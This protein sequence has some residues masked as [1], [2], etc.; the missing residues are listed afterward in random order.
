[1]LGE[2]ISHYRIREELGRGGMGVVY[3]AED[4]RLGRLVALKFVPDT[5]AA[6]AQALERFRRE[7]QAASRLNHPN[8]CTVFDVG[9]H[10]GRPFIIMELLE[11]RT[12]FQHIGRSPLPVEQILELGIQLAD[13]ID[14]A[15]RTGIIHRDIKSTNIFV[16]SRGQAKVLDFGLVKLQKQSGAPS[17]L[18]ETESLPPESLT[19]PGTAIGTVAWMSPEQARGEDVDQRSDVYSL[20]VVLYEMATGTLPFRGK[21][22]AIIFDAILNQPPEAASDR[23]P[24]LPAELARILHRALEKDREVRYQTA[25]DLRADLTR[26]QRDITSGKLAVETKRLSETRR[27]AARPQRQTKAVMGAA[28]CLLIVVTAIGWA[29]WR[30]GAENDRRS[31]PREGM[32]PS[33]LIERPLTANPPENF[34]ETAAISPQGTYLAYNGIYEKLVLRAVHSGEILAV[35]LPEGMSVYHVSWFPEE[36]RLLLT[37]ADARGQRS[38]WVTYIAGGAPRKL[39]GDV[40]LESAVSPNGQQIAFTTSDSQEIWLMSTSGQNARRLLQGDAGDEF[41]SLDWYPGGHRILYAR[42]TPPPTGWAA[43][44]ES[45]DTIDAQPTSILADIGLTSSDSPSCCCLPNGTVVYSLQDTERETANLWAVSTDPVTGQPLGTPREIADDSGF[46]SSVCNAT[47]DGRQLA[48][49]RSRAQFDVYVAELQP[50]SNRLLSPRRLTLDD[51]DDKLDSWLDN[52]T[53]LF[54]S[55]RS[56]TFDIYQQAI[57][58]G[59]ARVVIATSEDDLGG[60]TN[61]DGSLLI[62]A[63]TPSLLELNQGGAAELFCTPIDGGTPRSLGTFRHASFRCAPS[64]DAPNVVSERQPMHLVF[65][66]LDLNSGRGP[67]LARVEIGQAGHRDWDLAADGN[68]IVVAGDECLQI[69]SLDNGRVETLPVSG[70]SKFQRVA[71][72]ANGQGVFATPLESDDYLLL[73]IGL[74][75][76]TRE[77]WRNKS[78]WVARL[79]PSPDGRHLAFMAMT[80]ESNVW[81]LENFLPVAPPMKSSR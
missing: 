37:L 39:R 79:R 10:A 36:T 40:G 43:A 33:I 30:A 71:W 28:A 80:F 42:L 52:Q 70:Y 21:T 59:P 45:C 14:A 51:R 77:V 15:H 1:M 38:I 49:R 3:Q 81:L 74:D 64:A 61:H 19:S 13:A 16:S 2:T 11:G 54:S 73:Y 47:L 22:T 20:G 68:R 24:E 8:I 17:L 26:L 23:N 78:Q 9:E 56:G 53:V 75:G 44:L 72:A 29:T 67:E 34:L 76:Q 58:G 60:Q 32:T 25:S 35:E 41:C 62:H 48:I 7:A 12:L 55:D 27:S 6:D 18:G 66:E 65:F 63:S 31:H 50:D 4:T 46:S 57:D 69:V 5:M